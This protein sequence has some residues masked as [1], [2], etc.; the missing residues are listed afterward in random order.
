MAMEPN[1]DLDAATIEAIQDLIQVNLDAAGGFKEAAKEIDDGI[2]SGLFSAISVQRGKHASQLQDYVVRNGERA[3]TEGTWLAALHRVWLDLRAKLSGG[4]PYVLLCEVER[5]EDHIQAAYEETL[6]QTA[7]SALNDVLTKQYASVKDEH[8]Q[9]CALRK[10][11]KQKDAS[12]LIAS[13]N[14]R[15]NKSN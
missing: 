12:Q 4:D 5:G 11:Y 8:D 3:R 9:M 14:R 13:R 6:K 15:R 7:G 1:L 10:S 2:V